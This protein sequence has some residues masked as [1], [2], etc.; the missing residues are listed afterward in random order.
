M[1]SD[2]QRNAS[3]GSAASS[4][5]S[6]TAIGTGGA[7]SFGGTAPTGPGVPAGA[8]GSA[9]ADVVSPGQVLD[10]RYRIV[11]KLGEG[12]MGEV[13]AAE[14]VHIEKRVAV[15]LLR[16]EILANPEAVTRFRQEARSA[17]SIGHKNIISIEDFG[18]LTDGRIYLC[19]ELLEGE[20]LNDLLEQPLGPERILNILI[21]TCHGLAAAHE[22]GI[23]HRDMKPENIFVTIAPDGTEIPKLLDFGIAKVSG[24]DGD[25]GLTRTGTIFGTP[26]YMS[27]EQA[28]G[29][30]VDHRA[31]IYAMG[32]IMYECFAGSIPFSGE[33]FMGILTKHITAE[34]DP[35]AR[36]ALE[37]GRTIPPGIEPI[38]LHAMRKEPDQR[39]QTM[40]ELIEA[41]IAVHRNLAGPGM[42]GYMEPHVMGS[43]ALPGLRYGSSGQQSPTPV[44]QTHRHPSQPVPLLD[45][46]GRPATP[47]PT[48][49]RPG[50]S[51]PAPYTADAS[52]TPMPVSAS[53]TGSQ[54]AQPLIPGASPGASADFGPAPR[55]SSLGLVLAVLAV[56]LLGGAAGAYVLTDGF[57]G[58]LAGLGG[59]GD[60]E[61]GGELAGNIG[62]GTDGDIGDGDFGGHDPVPTPVGAGTE[63]ADAGPAHG[64]DDRG[65][66]PPN[67][68]NDGTDPDGAYISTI[69][70]LNADPEA[71]VFLEGVLVGKTP[72][73]VR[74]KPG[75]V[76]S[77]VLRRSG[78]LD[79]EIE[80]DD[81]APKR[82]VE[83]ERKRRRG[84]G[85]AGRGGDDDDDPRGTD[86]PRDPDKPTEPVKDPKKG[87]GELALP[88]E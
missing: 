73:N 15:K 5:S 49:H 21:Q 71:T 74:V 46:D 55:R 40:A 7:A 60:G 13:Y 26:F 77:L 79:A 25:N 39:Y 56:L 65:G 83:L 42:S 68:T 44:P 17:S 14:H 88:L 35:P 38:I 59:E 30:R 28:L 51:T 61:L 48:P 19:M 66:E 8:T 85:R 32:V 23:V 2:E 75:E 64:A 54:H 72:V 12:G 10:G 70:L 41:L 29:Q 4:V 84:G 24:N 50:S 3:T 45:A 34:P 31:D 43:A 63:D 37:N 18:K 87:V 11:A 76:K 67:G 47:T 6:G 78:Y 62:D 58:G 20:P 52:H 69:V 36:R 1:S 16:H 27:P 82:T 81:S 53:P 9:S 86:K 57:R 22:K 33:S 80:L